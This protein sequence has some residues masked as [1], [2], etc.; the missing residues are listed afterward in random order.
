MSSEIYSNNKSGSDYDEPNA[1]IPDEPYFAIRR[2][3]R[4]KAHQ[5]RT[6]EKYGYEIT[7]GN[8]QIVFNE[9]TMLEMVNTING[10]FAIN[11]E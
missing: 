11:K 5:V 3:G 8:Q 4:G 10:F 7:L 9:R 1:N 6:G 2:F